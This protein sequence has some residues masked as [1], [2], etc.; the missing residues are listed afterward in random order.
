[1]NPRPSGYEPDE[2]PDCST[3]R[4][5]E[6]NSNE[7]WLVGETAATRSVGRRGRRNRNARRRTRRDFPPLKRQASGALPVAPRTGYDLLR[8]G[9]AIGGFEGD[10]HPQVEHVKRIELVLG[11]LVEPRGDWTRAACT[12]AGAVAP[13]ADSQM[14]ARMRR[15][16]ITE[17]ELASVSALRRA[18][19]RAGAGRADAA[20]VGRSR[21]RRTP[22]ATA[23][24][25]T[26]R[27]PSR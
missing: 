3:P 13:E 15:P 4:R 26:R 17:V 9:R 22:P 8:G 20:A 18:P 11:P 2:L 19:R 12:L 24:R 1:M 23:A 16:D 5:T 21:R 27:T 10:E 25:S 14:R 6:N 7:P